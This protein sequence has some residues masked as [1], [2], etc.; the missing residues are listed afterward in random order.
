MTMN[1]NLQHPWD[2]A[3]VDWDIASPV[4]V[5]EI[6]GFE[7][8]WVAEMAARYR[9]TYHV[10]EPQAWAHTRIRERFINANLTTRGSALVIH[11]YG[12]GP[13][14]QDVV[15]SGWGTDAASVLKTADWH[16]DHP[17]EGRNER[18]VSTL[19]AVA[20]ELGSLG[21]IDVAMMNIE[22]YEYILLPA[23]IDAGLMPQI[24]H[25]MVQFHTDYPASAAEARI[26]EQI[27][28]THDLIWEW[29]ALSAWSLR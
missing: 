1:A 11:P 14:D 24:R 25:L 22:G 15:I 10:Y 21:A 3:S 5:V 7:G 6:G 8:R 18:S 16:T 20:D 9:G 19:R 27:A 29:P 23:M 17:D 4:M 13:E 12:L 26:R 2:V 28:E